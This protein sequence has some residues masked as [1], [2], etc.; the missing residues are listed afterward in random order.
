MTSFRFMLVWVPEPV[1]QI[2]SGNSPDSLPSITSCAASTM[3]FAALLVEAAQLHVGFRRGALDDAEGADQRLRH[4]VAADLE[5]LQ[6]ALGL[7]APIAV[8]GHV[9]RTEA[10]GFAAGLAVIGLA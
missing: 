2:T 9:D 10:V 8:G 1:C 3:A 5:I 7:R 4:A 6:R